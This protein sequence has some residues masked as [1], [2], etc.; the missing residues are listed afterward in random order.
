[1]SNYQHILYEVSERILTITFNRPEQLNT[2]P[3]TMID[4]MIDA[5]D[6]A[7]RDDEVRAIVIT[8]KGRVFCGG[9][10]L[11]PPGGGGFAPDDPVYMPMR[12]TGRDVGGELTMRMFDCRKPLIVAFNGPAVGI[13]CSMMLPA[14]IRIASEAARFAFP[15]VRR[16][17]VP[18]SCASWFLPRIVGISRALAWT[19]TGR[20][21]TV[22]EALGAGLI[23]EITSQERLMPRAYE[24][25]RDIAINTSAISVALTRQ[26]MWKLLSA[27]HPI[28]AN[29]LESKALEALI[30]GPDAREGVTAFKEKREPDFRLRPGSDMPSFYPWWQPPDF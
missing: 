18:E 11:S 28:E 27:D 24:I 19:V 15:F 12:G 7:D 2:V 8:A 13:G 4:E 9:T 3:F 10:D 17:I 1:M 20:N 23:Q 25:A 22:E 5:I 21:I 14:D 30:A 26:M 6:R 16:G 29:R